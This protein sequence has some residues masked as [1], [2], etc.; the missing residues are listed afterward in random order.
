V[1]IE[2]QRLAEM[3]HRV[4]PEPSRGV[5]VEDVAIRLANT[6][7]GSPR[8]SRSGGSRSGGSRSG[9]GPSRGPNDTAVIRGPG[10][11]GRGRR[12]SPLLAAAS[13]VVVIAASTGL[14]VALTS[15]NSPAHPAAGATSSPTSGQATPSYQSSTTATAPTSAPAT[16]PAMTPVRIA[17]GPWDAELID[18]D[19]LT[20]GTLVGSG[21]SLYAIA[22]GYLLRIDPKSGAVEEEVQY[23][24]PFSGQP[25]VVDGSTI[26]V[27][28]SYG[29]GTVG[30]R[31]YDAQTLAPTGSV[32]VASSVSLASEP[33]GILA[34][35]PDGTLYVAA[36][37]SVAVVSPSSGSVVRR[38]S[39]SGGPAD[40][41]A[42]TPDGGTLYVGTAGAVS[43]GLV[44]YNP[45]TGAQVAADHQVADQP[46]N[47]VATSGGAFGTNGVSMGEAVWFFPASDLA[48]AKQVAQAA[49]GGSVAVPTLA[50]GTV[51]VGGT[52]QLECLGAVSGVLENSGAI[53]SVD[54][55]PDQFGSVAYADGNA[56]VIYLNPHTQQGGIAKITPPNTC[57]G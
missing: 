37:N 50:D 40:S 23:S 14:A 19:A 55:I 36:G 44:S 46:G 29:G 54:G 2:E 5:T 35:G 39:V 51:W 18:S 9:G 6:G 27:V 42:I 11:P 56:Y 33:E 8:R 49:N 17:N 22:A 24:A 53:S 34:A 20:P 26:W 45:A 13:V 4:T 28:S 38:I 16:G 41:V 1:T 15:H 25:P 43:F 10:R 31:G 30:L 21:N 32:T 7:A 48:S 47:L 12:W 57:I 52:R 3:L